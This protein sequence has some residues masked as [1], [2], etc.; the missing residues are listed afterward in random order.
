MVA[1]KNLLGYQSELDKKEKSR[2]QDH[3]KELQSQ[4]SVLDSNV[5]S[6]KSQ[7]EGREALL[8]TTLDHLQKKVIFF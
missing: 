1:R 5:N 2:L 8:D 6:M 3:V 4:I 7:L